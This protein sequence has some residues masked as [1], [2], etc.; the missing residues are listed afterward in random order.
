MSM[1]FVRFEAKGA[2]VSPVEL[3]RSGA[4]RTNLNRVESAFLE[5]G[6]RNTVPEGPV[7]IKF[8]LK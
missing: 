3:V 1:D 2:F 8:S 4:G 7:K 6:E 5:A